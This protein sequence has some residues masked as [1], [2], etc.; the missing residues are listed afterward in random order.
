MSYRGKWYDIEGTIN[1]RILA[2]IAKPSPKLGQSLG[3]LG[4][5]MVKFC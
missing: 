1:M 3:P 5:N 2:G 4:V